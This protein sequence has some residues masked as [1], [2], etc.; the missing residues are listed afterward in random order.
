MTGEQVGI[1]Q[2]LAGQP[3][4][5]QDQRASEVGGNALEPE[6]S[7]YQPTA[8][9]SL[10]GSEPPMRTPVSGSRWITWPPPMLARL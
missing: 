10:R 4:A 8:A 3:D 5:F 7:S 9:P 6:L 2:T 1:H